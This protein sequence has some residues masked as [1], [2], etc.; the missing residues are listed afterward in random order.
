MGYKERALT[1]NGGGTVSQRQQSQPVAKQEELSQITKELQNAQ[2]Q[3]LVT[4]LRW[5]Q[6][7][8]ASRQEGKYNFRDTDIACFH[9]FPMRRRRWTWPGVL[10]TLS[11]TNYLTPCGTDS[12]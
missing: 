5:Q 10:E 7:M 2:E 4:E 3:A 9:W 11:S 6:M 8:G 12:G 1:T